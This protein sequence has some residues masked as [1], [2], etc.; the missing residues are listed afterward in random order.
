MYTVFDFCKVCQ[1]CSLYL[2]RAGALRGLVLER[3]VGAG[4][5]RGAARL[6]AQGAGAGSGVKQ[7]REVDS[8][9]CVALSSKI[10]RFL[11]GRTDGRTH[12]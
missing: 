7:L 3:G 5:A 6:A 9:G 11:D 12:V 2:Y 8:I 4:A 1:E 10:F